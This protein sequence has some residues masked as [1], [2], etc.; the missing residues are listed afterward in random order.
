MIKIY[1]VT[2]PVVLCGCERWTLTK[3]YD[4]KFRIFETGD[5]KENNVLSSV[6]GV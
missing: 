5:F 1:T 2:I 3:N 6:N 4:G